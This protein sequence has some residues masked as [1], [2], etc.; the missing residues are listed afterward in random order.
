MHWTEP[1]SSDDSYFGLE[2]KLGDVSYKLLRGGMKATL[3]DTKN[4]GQRS[5]MVRV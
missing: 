5:E 1:A 2:Q 3:P 4:G